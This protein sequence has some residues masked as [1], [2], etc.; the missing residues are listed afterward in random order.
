[1]LSHKSHHYLSLELK[2][3]KSDSV[4]LSDFCFNW[5][6]LIE[7]VEHKHYMKMSTVNRCLLGLNHC[8]NKH[9]SS[10]PSGLTGYV[11]INAPSSRRIFLYVSPE[12]YAHLLL[13]IWLLAASSRM[14]QCWK[15]EY[16]PCGFYFYFK[17]FL[18]STQAR[19]CNSSVE[20]INSLHL[21]GI[22][23]NIH[24]SLRVLVSG[25]QRECHSD[26][27]LQD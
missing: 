22:N 16:W 6:S 9:L 20:F 5:F 13:D 8:Q 21:M 2:T 10:A 23:K 4:F 19:W 26:V 7:H 3:K 25:K 12:T 27:C 17:K 18:L 11:A 14:R 15:D 24:N 1:M